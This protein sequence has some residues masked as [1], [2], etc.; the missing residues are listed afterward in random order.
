M[1]YPKEIYLDGY[2]YTQMYEHEKGG[3]YYH[4]E[5]CSDVITGSFISLYL[6]GRLTYLWDGYEHGYGKY[7]FENNKKIGGENI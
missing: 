4:S 7:D 1:E 3:T 2:T 5:E 6:N